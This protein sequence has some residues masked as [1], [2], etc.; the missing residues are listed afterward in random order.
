MLD[1]MSFLLVINQYYI[2]NFIDILK[3]VYMT[4]DTEFI[5]PL[6][7]PVYNHIICNLPV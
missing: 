6:T 5:L 4:V 1:F 7:Y 3:S 2:L